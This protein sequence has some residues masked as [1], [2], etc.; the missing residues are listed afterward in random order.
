MRTMRR[1]HEARE[2]FLKVK[3]FEN[4]LFWSVLVRSLTRG[5]VLAA[6]SKTEFDKLKN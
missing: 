2:V 1:T 3:K 6:G 5:F 4:I